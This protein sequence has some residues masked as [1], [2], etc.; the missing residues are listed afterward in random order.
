MKG[1]SNNEESN[2]AGKTQQWYSSSS[3][4]LRNVSLTKQKKCVRAC[5]YAFQS[6][7][8]TLAELCLDSRLELWATQQPEQG[9]RWASTTALDGLTKFQT[10]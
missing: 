6:M 7:G 3:P 10:R 1:C 9:H 2:T 4:W 8:S 5:L